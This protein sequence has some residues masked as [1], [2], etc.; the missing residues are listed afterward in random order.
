MHVDGGVVG[1]S[2]YSSPLRFTIAI[3]M[4]FVLHLTAQELRSVLQDAVLDVGK[5]FG[6]NLETDV[7]VAIAH[8][9]FGR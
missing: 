8:S 4:L 7:V 2:R 9:Q 1:S 3:F 5:L 6:A